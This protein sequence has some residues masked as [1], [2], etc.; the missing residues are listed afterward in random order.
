M[1]VQSNT[2]ELGQRPEQGQGGLQRKLGVFSIILMVVAGAAPLAVVSFS[3]PMIL[4]VTETITLP[5]YYAIAGVIVAVFAVGYLAMTK[6]VPNATAFYTYVQA[7]LGRI[8]GTGAAF[9]GLAA[10]VLLVVSIFTYGGMM[11]Q[12]LVLGYFNVDIPW[13]VWSM[14]QMVIIGFIGYRAADFGVK[15]LMVLVGAEVAVIL[16]ANTA[17]F[18]QGG[19][20]GLDAR[21][22]NPGLVEG[23]TLGLGILFAAMG[24]Y[25]FEA[26]AVFRGE[27]KNPDKTIPRAAYIGVLVIGIFYVVSSWLIVMGAGSS[28]AV[29]MAGEEPETLV[30]TLGAIFVG[31]AF[32]ELMLILVITSTFACA[33][34]FHNIIARYLFTLGRAGAVPQWLGRPHPKFKAPSRASV[35][36]TIT[37][38]ALLAIAV[39]AG[40]DPYMEL[41]IWFDGAGGLALIASMALTSVAIIAFFARTKMDSR[42]WQTRIAPGLAALGLGAVLFFVVRYFPILVE[43]TTAALVI[44]IGMVGLFLAGVLYAMF[45]KFNR[46]ARYARLQVLSDEDAAEMDFIDK[47]QEQ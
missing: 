2:T 10:Y 35:V 15:V 20:E 30:L 24:Y 6:H 3:L 13:W 46:P 17:I 36:V 14:L 19:A 9:L 32:P 7:G 18:L 8:P 12:D 43:S 29:A 16:I 23:S 38:L 22:F 27:A 47:G 41:M 39:V 42:V 25:G 11:L 26:T 40:L 45:L 37:T 33:L 5:I 44:G 1:T 21:P 34:A 31:S 28:N 4:V